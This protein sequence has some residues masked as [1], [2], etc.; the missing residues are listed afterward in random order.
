MDCN[1]PDKFADLSRFKEYRQYIF[2]GPLSNYGK[3]KKCGCIGTWIGEGEREIYRFVIWQLYVL[4]HTRQSGET[5]TS[6]SAGH[7]IL[8]PTQAVESGLPQQETNPGPPHQESRALPTEQLRPQY[9]PAVQDWYWGSS[10]Y[11]T[12]LTYASWF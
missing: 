1:A 11:L 4:P 5:M 9:G 3:K 10:G 6:V 8:T 7:I 12:Y 2:N